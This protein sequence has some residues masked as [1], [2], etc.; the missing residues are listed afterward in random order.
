MSSSYER[1]QAEI[2]RLEMEMRI[3][4]DSG[5]DYDD[6]DEYDDAAPGDDFYG[7]DDDEEI[8]D[9]DEIWMDVEK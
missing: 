2:D 4:D 9:E 3:A 1:H 8:L 6:D 5:N 7:D